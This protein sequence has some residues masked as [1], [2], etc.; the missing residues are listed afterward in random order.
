MARWKE[1]IE[2]LYDV[3]NKSRAEDM[4]VEEG[5]EVN[6]DNKGCCTLKSE[7]LKSMKEMKMEKQWELAIYQLNY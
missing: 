7:I 4:K 5:M 2:N 1:Y 3:E 6:E